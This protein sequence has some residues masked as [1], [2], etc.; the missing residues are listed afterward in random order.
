MQARNPLLLY[1][2]VNGIDLGIFRAEMV[3][4]NRRL[5]VWDVADGKEIYRLEGHGED[6]VYSVAWSSDGGLLATGGADGR[7]Y[8]LL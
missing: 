1:T 3:E 7:F 6:A 2:R 4:K 8:D 5:Q